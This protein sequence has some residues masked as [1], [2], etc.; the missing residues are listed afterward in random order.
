MFKMTKAQAAADLDWNRIWHTGSFMV[1]DP[2]D[3]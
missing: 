2:V 1:T 3:R